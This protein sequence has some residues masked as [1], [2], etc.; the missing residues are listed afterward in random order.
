MGRTLCKF[1][2]GWNPPPP[3]LPAKRQLERFYPI[4]QNT[5]PGAA[6]GANFETSSP[7]GNNRTT[8]NMS[9]KYFEQFSSKIFI[10]W[11]RVANSAVHGSIRPNFK[12]FRY[13]IVVL[14]TCKN[15]EDPTNLQNEGAR[16][17]TSLYINFS[18]AQC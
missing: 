17:L 12:L 18:D 9:S 10:N 1:Y 16:V 6:V 4:S 13:Y 15:K 11:S 8:H 14:G 7:K 3:P 2:I 5:P